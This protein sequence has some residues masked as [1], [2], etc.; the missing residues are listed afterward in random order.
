PVYLRQ[1]RLVWKDII[2]HDI[3]GK[4]QIK[5]GVGFM[6]DEKGGWFLLEK[7]NKENAFIERV[8]YSEPT[9]VAMYQIGVDTTQDRIAVNG[10]D[11]AIVIFKKSCTV[12]GE[13]TGL[14]PV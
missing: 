14:Y 5:K 11:P 10:S 3:F 4:P 13:E 1:C 2:E 9:N 12:N 6:D 8:S 7:P